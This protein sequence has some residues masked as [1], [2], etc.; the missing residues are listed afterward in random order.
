MKTGDFS[1]TILSIDILPSAERPA[2]LTK[3]KVEGSDPAN[4]TVTHGIR[5]NSSDSCRIGFDEFRGAFP[6]LAALDDE[7]L[8]T[9]LVEH[10]AEF[11]GLKVTVGI[12][13]QLRNGVPVT[14]SKGNAYYNIRLRSTLRNLKHDEASNLAKVLLGSVVAERAKKQKEEE[15]KRAAANESDEPS[16]KDMEPSH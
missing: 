5:L 1:G 13:K 14:D 16:L 12:E 4:L 11:T 8:L 9:H 6:K 7:G 10:T 3:I 2:V 15:A